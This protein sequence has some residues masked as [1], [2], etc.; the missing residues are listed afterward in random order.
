MKTIQPMTFDTDTLNSAL[1]MSL[2]RAY[3]KAVTMGE[4]ETTILSAFACVSAEN[5]P[6]LVTQGQYYAWHDNG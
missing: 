5:L 4:A 1:S 2:D 3:L 6:H